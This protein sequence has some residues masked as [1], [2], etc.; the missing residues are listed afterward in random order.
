MF[1]RNFLTQLQRATADGVPVTG[2]FHWSMMDNFE[3]M[4]G[5]GNRFGIVYVEF[6]TLERRPKLSAEWFQKPPN[7]TSSSSLQLHRP[8]ASN[9]TSTYRV[10]HLL[11]SHR[12]VARRGC[13]LAARRKQARTCLAGATT[14]R[15]DRLAPRSATPRRR[16]RGGSASLPRRLGMH[17]GPHQP[18]S[19]FRPRSSLGPARRQLR[20]R[21]PRWLPWCR[22]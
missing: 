15:V 21:P 16:R 12:A 11:A 3:W 9:L 2:Y 19:M 22:K 18:E 17:R 13:A 7:R 5:Y 10:R 6:E 8:N 20:D 4:A 1:M 14:S